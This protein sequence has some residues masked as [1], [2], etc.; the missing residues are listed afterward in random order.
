M[1]DRFEVVGIYVFPNSLNLHVCNKWDSSLNVDVGQRKDKHVQN[2]S[3]VN[4]R[5]IN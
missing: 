5:N 4:M 2:R 1:S 3:F